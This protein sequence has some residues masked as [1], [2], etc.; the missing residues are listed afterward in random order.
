MLLAEELR[1]EI[2]TILWGA[3][4]VAAVAV[5]IAIWAAVKVGADSERRS[6]FDPKE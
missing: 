1:M 5:G 6:K 3:V 4:I 2:R